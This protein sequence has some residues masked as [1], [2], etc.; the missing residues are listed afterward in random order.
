MQNFANAKLLCW[1]F[2]HWQLQRLRQSVWQVI[3]YAD[4]KLLVSHNVQFFART[5]ISIV[6]SKTVEKIC[7]WKGKSSHVLLI[8]N[9]WIDATELPEGSIVI[10][11]IVIIT[12]LFDRKLCAAF[13]R[14]P[15]REH[16]LRQCGR[17]ST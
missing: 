16:Q 3:F 10:L 12:V 13:A 5:K 8:D 9:S 17:I 11:P 4:A 15:A 2:P 6:T 14:L 1:N 7:S